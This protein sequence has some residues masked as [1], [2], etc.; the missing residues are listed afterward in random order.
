MIVEIRP[1]VT[2]EIE[3]VVHGFSPPR[4]TVQEM[5]LAI[6]R[7]IGSITFSERQVHQAR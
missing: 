2:M 3:V 4:E 5:L 7:F 1:S 6:M